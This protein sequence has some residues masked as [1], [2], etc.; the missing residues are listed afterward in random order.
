MEEIYTK[1]ICEG[2]TVAFRYIISTYKDMAFSVASSI[3]KDN[4]AA[5]EVVQIAFIK[6]Y[7]NI[8]SFRKGSKFSTW[9]YRIVVNE[10]FMYIKKKKREIIQW[11]EELDVDLLDEDHFNSAEREEQNF[12]ITEGLKRLNP[13]E[14]LTLRLFY[15]DEQNIRTVA[16]ITGWSESNVKI[17]LYR[18]RKNMLNIISKLMKSRS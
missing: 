3:I 5:E 16:D 4:Y 13:N 1:K 6:A 17:H 12:L 14:S 7:K 10:S 15:L 11:E 8:K 18:G 2:D 9:F